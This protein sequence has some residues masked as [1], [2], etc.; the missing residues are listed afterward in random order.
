MS[1]S[2]AYDET[3]RPTRR[4]VSQ[5]LATVATWVP[6]PARSSFTLTARPRAAPRTRN[7]TDVGAASYATK[8][9]RCG[10]GCGRSPAATCAACSSRQTVI[11]DDTRHHVV[12]A[13]S[14]T[15]VDGQVQ[16]ITGVGVAW[17]VTCGNDYS[18]LHAATSDN[19]DSGS[20]SPPSD[21]SVCSIQRPRSV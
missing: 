21:T 19:R 9:T 6:V 2:V 1:R 18:A 16:R 8:A 3:V 14:R 10:A 17:H 5:P 15:A 12:T 11:D 7:R 13:W 20:S 4:S